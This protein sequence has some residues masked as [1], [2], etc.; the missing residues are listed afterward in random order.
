[1]S[2]V[3]TNVTSSRIEVNRISV[4]NVSKQENPDDSKADG[5]K[6]ATIEHKTTKD[7][8]LETVDTQG[9]HGVYDGEVVWFS[10]SRRSDVS[11]DP[12]AGIND[13]PAQDM[14]QFRCTLR[15][16]D[17]KEMGLGGAL[18]LSDKGPFEACGG[19]MRRPGRQR[20]HGRQ[21]TYERPTPL[22]LCH[23]SRS[24]IR[25]VPLLARV[26]QQQT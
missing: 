5:H 15:A 9:Q 12:I 26:S 10:P 3:T 21:V 17:E 19:P 23:A 25:R 18:S 22:L 14:W 20:T 24:T 6:R 11:S 8:A 2:F 1:M 13:R 7:R 4:Q 16:V